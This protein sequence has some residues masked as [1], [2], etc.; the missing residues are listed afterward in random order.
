VIRLFGHLYAPEDRGLCLVTVEGDRIASVEPAGRADAPPPGAL[1]GP[2][3]RILPGL[4]DIQINGA[5]GDDF[6]DPGARMDVICR[7]LPR[8][9]VTGFVPTIVTSA[10]DA[11]GPALANLRRSPDGRGARV[12]GV[13]IEGPYISPKQPG[14]H[15]PAQLRLPDIREAASW[16]E[17]GSVAW[18]TLAP[19]LP[20][21]LEVIEFL[22]GAGVRVSMG[23]T[24]ATWGQ[25]AAAVD[26]GATL[27][28]HLFN[29]MRPFRHRDPGVAGYVLASHITAGF[30]ADGN[31]IAFETIRLL[32][33]IKSPDEMILVT[34]ALAG[35]GMPPGRYWLAGREYISD[36]TCGRLPDGTLSGS[37]LPLNLALRNV[38]DKAGVE[39]SLA[40]RFATLNPAR[41]LGLEATHGR[42]EVGRQADLALVDDRWAVLATVAG[43]EVAYSAA[44]GQEAHTA[45]DVEPTAAARA[46]GEA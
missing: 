5:F 20:G 15:D 45:P 19:E 37:L 26:A 14:T 12:L 8:F 4:L 46:G 6:A 31:H 2:S 25:A 39:P 42:V 36:G 18:L 10:P 35:L 17:S 23:H 16:L 21:A 33:R 24:D 22:T 7:D 30:I 13:H 44:A 28:T 38:V 32:A 43:G 3:A 29:A 41:A 34:D 11:Y 27:A 1:G 40:V 9:G